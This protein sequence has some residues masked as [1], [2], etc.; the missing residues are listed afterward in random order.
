MGCS[1]SRTTI[2]KVCCG[3]VEAGL[4]R[5]VRGADDPAVAPAE[6]RPGG[7]VAVAPAA[8][9]DDPVVLF[10][11]GERGGGEVVADHPA[12]LGHVID[13][14]LLRRLRPVV[15]LVVQHDQ[16]VRGEV[17]PEAA[18]VLA[19]RRRG[20][21]VDRKQP[22]LFQE[23]LENGRGLF[24]IVA[25]L[26]VDDQGLHRRR[27]GSG[28]HDEPNCNAGRKAMRRHGSTPVSGGWGG[29]PEVPPV[30]RTGIVPSSIAVSHG[31]T[32]ANAWS[33]QRPTVAANRR[34]QT[35]S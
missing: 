33:C 18:H 17:G 31:R 1:G 28:G 24:P 4:A 2:W 11:L 26:A 6:V 13:K 35:P 25:V 19:V 15:P 20:G 16:L 10:P 22:G 21:H 14:R 7:L 29:I 34:P 32:F 27:G 5:R 3:A 23:L 9:A 12:P 30:Y 8:D